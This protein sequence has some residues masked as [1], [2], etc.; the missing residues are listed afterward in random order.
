MKKT[1]K[2]VLVAVMA[3]AMLMSCLVGCG[4][5]ETKDEGAIISQL[6]ADIVALDP[7]R[8]YDIS[9]MQV[10]GQVTENILAQ[11]MDGSMKPHLAKSWEAVDELTYVYT[12]RDDVKFS[13]GDPMTMEDVLFSLKRHMDPEV[14]SYLGWMVENVESIEQTGDWEF[15]VKLYEPDATFQ[16]VFGTSVGSV[17]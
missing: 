14:A 8:S 13:N 10:L 2:K 6:M 1:L 4:K 11:Q 5:E 15:T 3:L 9:T 16:Y 7:A 17:I 12:M